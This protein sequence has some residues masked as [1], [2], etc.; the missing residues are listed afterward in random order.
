M[1]CRLKIK[2]Q[3][4]KPTHGYGLDALNWFLVRA[5][6]VFANRF[7]SDVFLNYCQ[8][9]LPFISLTQYDVHYYQLDTV[10]AK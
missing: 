4:E 1:F 9:S 2:Y 5:Y 3:Q 6:F 8:K 7:L 10:K